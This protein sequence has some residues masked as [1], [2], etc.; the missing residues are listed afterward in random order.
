M[1][2]LTSFAWGVVVV[3]TVVVGVVV[4]IVTIVGPFMIKKCISPHCFYSEITRARGL[5][6]GL[7]GKEGITL[8]SAHQVKG[9]KLVERYFCRPL[10]GRNCC[11]FFVSVCTASDLGRFIFTLNGKVFRGLGPRKGGFVSHFFSVV[12]SLEVKFGLSDVAKRPVLRLNLKSVRTPRAALRRVFVCLR[13]TSGPYVMTVS[14][15]RR[16][17]SCPRGGLR[18]VLEAGIRRY[19]GSG[20]I[21]TKDRERVVVGVF[22]DPSEPFCRDIDVVRLKTVPL[23]MCGPFIGKLF[24]RG[25]GGIASRLMRGMCA[26]FSKR[27]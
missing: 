9:A 26:L 20:F 3:F 5:V 27:A 6:H 1:F 15:F 21:F 16:V 18:T 14:R 11:A 22:G 17:D 25:N 12:A 7:V 8:I 4:L 13:R 24:R 2:S 23:R 19:D 10:V